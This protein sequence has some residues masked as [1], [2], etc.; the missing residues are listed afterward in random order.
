[1]SDPVAPRARVGT[2]AG[3][4]LVTLSTLVLEIA[5]TRIFSV[6]M[7]YHFAFVAISVALFGLTAGALIV[8]LLPARFPE[9]EVK[10]QLWVFALLFAVA[11]AVCFAAQLMIPFT[12]RLTI[13]G[14]ASVVGTCVVIA[15]PFVFSG[16]VVCLALTRFPARVNRLYAADLVGAG[17]GCIALVI[18]FSW[19]D[20]PSLIVL[21]AGVAAAG[22]LA[23]A[24]DAGNRRGVAL[25]ST[26]VIALG[27]FVAL[28]TYL[29]SKGDPLLNIVWVKETRDP[30]HDYERWNAFSRLTVQGDPE[31]PATPS[32]GL[33]ID[34][35]AGTKLNRYSGDPTE[36]DFLRREVQNL[37]HYIRPDADVFVIGVGGG[38]DV[39]SA[40]EF[41]QRS[42]T[43]LEINGD[44]IDIAHRRYADF[45]G[46]LAD[47]PR[48]EIV[49]DEARSF[50]ARTER[51]YDLIQISLIDTW[52]ATG[53]GAFALTENSLYTTEAW[54][55]FLERLQRGGLLSVTRF[56]QTEN[57][58]GEAVE[59]VETYR[60][61]ALAAEVLTRRGVEAPREH[62]AMFRAPTDFGVDLASL[63]VS[64]DPLSKAD[65]ATLSERAHE[66]GFSRLLTPAGSADPMLESLTAPGGPGPAV[67]DLA[68]DISPPG[69]NRPFFFQMADLDTFRH[70]NILRDDFVTRPVLTLGGLGLVVVGMAALCI[71]FPLLIARRRP[72]DDLPA[73]RQWLPFCTYFA[74]I[75]L[76]F[77]MIEVAQ[78]QRLSIFLG[79]PIYGLSVVLFAI[80]VFGG[81]GS[82]LTE[83]FLRVTRP[84]SLIAPL[85]GLMVVVGIVGVATPEVLKAMDAGTT[86]VRIATA[87]ALLAPLALAMGMPFA[88]GMRAAAASPGA[89]TAYLWAINGAMSV[90]GS[91]LGLVIALF[92]GISVAFWSGALAYAMALVSIVAIARRDVP[93]VQEPEQALTRV[94]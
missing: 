90:C 48:V 62:L 55:L 74:G 12:P 84:S 88:V 85:A 42:V 3:L 25:A 21:V 5:L 27:G 46:H 91:V 41:N 75:G 57:D 30:D 43:G 10:R 53:A 24:A 89:P 49:N 59:P 18:L 32:L 11:V 16:V 67:A 36:S 38:S 70:G 44:I 7:W 33:T 68:A 17:L 54:D 19:F 71:A 77:L 51:T 72:R 69:D 66:F 79:H 34:S 4:L 23:F 63:V 14:V 78:L 86:P 65:V 80:L 1:M 40:L 52:A 50:L 26:A 94:G 92:L 29:H 45:T 93:R 83:R 82:L 31:D 13:G 28:N 60:A 47:H 35:T 73:L 37:S 15:I 9:A 81:I 56:Y 22:A 8:H 6:T 58:G 64:R 39:L 76:G 20:G 61:V 87:V 2:Y